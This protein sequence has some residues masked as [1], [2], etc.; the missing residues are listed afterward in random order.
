MS[1]VEAIKKLLDQAPKGLIDEIKE[2]APALVAL[3]TGKGYE[4]WD[5]WAQATEQA[6]RD[7]AVVAETL[8]ER[9]EARLNW[10][11]LRRL[12]A[13]PPML[14]DLARAVDSSPDPVSGSGGVDEAP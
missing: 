12:R 1:N 2:N 8:E 5:R 13:I 14:A 4:L 3:V 7:N 9:E 10:Q 11:A 6:L